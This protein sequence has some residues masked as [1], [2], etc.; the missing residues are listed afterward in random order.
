MVL[1]GTVMVLR[2]ERAQVTA[3]NQ[4]LTA[5]SLNVAE[6][7]VGRVLDLL[8]KNPT[9]SLYN[10]SRWQTATN[11]Q[12]GIPG[13]TSC[14]NTG[15]T[16]SIQQFAVNA[17]SWGNIDAADASKGQYKIVDYAYTGAQP[18]ANT[19]AYTN[20]GTGTLTIQGRTN[21]S[22]AATNLQVNV[23]VSSGGFRGVPFP[24][25]WLTGSS[26]GGPSGNQSVAG[27]VFLNNCSGT[28][29]LDSGTDPSTGQAWQVLHP[30]LQMPS[31]P[32]EPTGIINLSTRLVG[33]NVSMTLPAVNDLL[34]TLGTQQVYAYKIPGSLDKATITVPAGQKVYIWLGGNIEKN[35]EIIHECGNVS[36]CKPTDVQIYASGSAITAPAVP[37]MCLNGNRELHAFVLAPNYAIGVTGG[38]A[39][40]G[41]LWAKSWGGVQS[42]NSN[43]NHTVVNQTG[44][45]AELAGVLSASTLPP[46]LD[47]IT[48]W[49]R[50]AYQ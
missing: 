34:S 40:K 45:W 25:L 29:N 49:Q 33:N 43:S 27:N 14:S 44:N 22:T 48:S 41:S 18:S 12:Q 47:Q 5:Q 46:K 30:S 37:S 21:N 28:A 35:S 8:S 42:C 7:G 13:P 10:F 15:A 6:S 32:A 23:P 31:L 39:F 26:T 9:I 20:L 19:P 24:G 2:T 16:T 11:A 50:G 36:G 3:S 4:A 1:V 38:G 17:A